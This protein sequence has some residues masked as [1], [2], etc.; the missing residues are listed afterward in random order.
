[1]TNKTEI[2]IKQNET[3]IIVPADFTMS[4]RLVVSDHAM[5]HV[6]HTQ[7]N[8]S[9]FV[10]IETMYQCIQACLNQPDSMVKC[11]QRMTAVKRFTYPI[12][13]SNKQTIGIVFKQ[14]KRVTFVIT[15]YP[16]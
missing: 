6:D 3:L 5:K 2:Y 15:A 13:L 10:N 12:G 8:S 1:M 16:I 4:K 7:E 14:T 9:F 11:K